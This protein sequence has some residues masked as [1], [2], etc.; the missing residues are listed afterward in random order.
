[1]TE[2]LPSV[3]C[4]GDFEVASTLHG[5]TGDVRR[6]FA[7]HA[8]LDVR[9]SAAWN[10][11]VLRP[12]VEQEPKAARFIAEGALMR[13]NAGA[14]CFARYRAELGLERGRRAG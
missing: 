3:A 2:V 4:V 9:H 14:R 6:Y 8:T 7:V 10:R 13:L 12:L 1:M 5:I 11:E